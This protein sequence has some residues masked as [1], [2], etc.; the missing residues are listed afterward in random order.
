MAAR[1]CR[2]FDLGLAPHHVG[3]HRSTWEH[4]GVLPGE[5]RCPRVAC[6][7]RICNLNHGFRWSDALKLCPCA[8]LRLPDTRRVLPYD[9]ECLATQGDTWVGLPRAR[10]TYSSTFNSTKYWPW[11]PR[12]GREGTSQCV[13]ACDQETVKKHHSTNCGQ[14]KQRHA[15]AA[16][17]LFLCHPTPTFAKRSIQIEWFES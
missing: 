16:M 14:S 1:L 4:F 3:S 7:V 13:G 8:S 5:L 10:N 11:R 2:P 15:M 6:G 17:A 12:G 9:T